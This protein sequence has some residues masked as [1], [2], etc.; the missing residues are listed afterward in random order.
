[1]CLG[2]SLTSQTTPEADS[3]P[4][5]ARECSTAEELGELIART[6]Y[7]VYSEPLPPQPAS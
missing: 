6:T 2:E 3:E 7:H 5:T 4:R 1:M